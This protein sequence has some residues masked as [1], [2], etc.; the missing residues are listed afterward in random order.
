MIDQLIT[1]LKYLSRICGFETADSFPPG[2]PHARTRWNGAYFDIASDVKPEQ[3]ERLLCQ[4]ITNTPLVFGSISN[5]TPAMQRALM[6]VLEERARRRIAVGDL[7]AL[8]IIAYDS[9]H[10]IEAVPGL[11]AE[12]EATRHEDMADRV[13]SMMAFLRA[14]QSPFDV[15]E[16]RH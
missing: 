2:H 6:A 13:R 16:M 11:R 5:P 3:I 14:M 10:T 1:W 9:P 8:L 7:G 12:I 15:I 4:A